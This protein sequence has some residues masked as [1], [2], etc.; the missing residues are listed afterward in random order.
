MMSKEKEVSQGAACS[1]IVTR[2]VV[3]TPVS[4]TPPA[5]S[6]R[7]MFAVEEGAAVRM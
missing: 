6:P 7:V 3:L 1:P 2:L 5:Q 4:P